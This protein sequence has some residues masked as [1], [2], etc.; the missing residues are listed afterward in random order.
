MQGPE[1]AL[2]AQED[3]AQG[4]QVA[5]QW[6]EQIDGLQIP[7]KYPNKMF[8]SDYYSII[9]CTTPKESTFFSA[10]KLWQSQLLNSEQQLNTGVYILAS[11]K[12]SSPP[13]LKFFPVFVGFFAVI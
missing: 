6:A 3:L 8:N 10:N 5:D 1:P 7:K 13:P 2:R 4:I 11:Q 12:N 9:F